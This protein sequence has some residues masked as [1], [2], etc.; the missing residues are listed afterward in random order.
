MNVAPVS[1]HEQI[2][3]KIYNLLQSIKH[4]MHDLQQATCAI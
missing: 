1:S 2:K 4:L 3:Y